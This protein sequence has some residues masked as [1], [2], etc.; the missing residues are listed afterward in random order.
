MRVEDIFSLKTSVFSVVSSLKE[1]VFELTE[2]KKSD[3]NPPAAVGADTESRG[4][5][6]SQKNHIL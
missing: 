1:E 6:F 3:E 4:T 5:L 2:E